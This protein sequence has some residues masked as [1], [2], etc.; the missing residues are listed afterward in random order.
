MKKTFPFLL[1][2][3]LLILMIIASYQRLTCAA[4]IW[5]GLPVDC[6]M[7]I[8]LLYF[9]W[10]CY[11]VTVTKN[12]TCQ[13][14]RQSD[15]GTREFYGI[16][17]ALVILSALFFE[18]IWERPGPAHLAGLALF[19]AGVGLRIGA[20]TTLGA[21][22]AHAV[23]VIEGHRII[24]TG[25]YRFIRHPAYAGNL[26]AHAGIVLFFLSELTLIFFIFVFVPAIIVRI[27]V[28]ERTLMKIEGY[29][30][31]ASTR[32]RLIPLIW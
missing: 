10:T 32:K 25:P 11:E 30:E 18:E 3:S 13:L 19:I 2:V 29:P 7:L 12:E 24:D 31:F 20:I 1:P 21:Y 5:A 22:Y 27:H 14:S 9:M 17:Q 23:R 26:A 4:N 15:M 28:E 8:I 6:E 16:A